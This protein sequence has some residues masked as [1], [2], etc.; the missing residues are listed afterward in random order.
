[1]P[2]VG[3]RFYIGD[4]SV[5]QLKTIPS[6]WYYTRFD[7]VDILCWSSG[8]SAYGSHF[9]PAICQWQEWNRWVLKLIWMGRQ[10]CSL[11]EPPNQDHRLTVVGQQQCLG[12]FEIKSEWNDHIDRNR[13]QDSKIYWLGAR[14]PYIMA[15]RNVFLWRHGH[16]SS[17]GWLRHRLWSWKHSGYRHRSIWEDQRESWPIHGR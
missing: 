2:V 14:L 16:F 3:A 12:R 1:M 17:S 7:A 11:R 4:G 15:T 5:E 8:V 10:T 6:D 13:G 9:Q